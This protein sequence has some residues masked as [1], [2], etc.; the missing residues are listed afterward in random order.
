[1]RTTTVLLS[2]TVRDNICR[3]GRGA[4]FLLSSYLGHPHPSADT[5]QLDPPFP[6]LSLFLLSVEQVDVRQQGRTPNR[7]TAKKPGI[8]PC[9]ISLAFE[10]GGNL[11]VNLKMILR[12]STNIAKTTQ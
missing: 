10:N 4:A 5:E 12:T 9:S 3:N 1:M 11:A 7:M 6:S 2:F 8:L